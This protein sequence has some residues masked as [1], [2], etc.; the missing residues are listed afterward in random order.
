MKRTH[1]TLLAALCLTVVSSAAVFA[2]EGSNNFKLGGTAVQ[3][4][5][6]ENAV[7]EVIKIRTDV[8]PYFGTVSRRLN[9]KVTKLDNLLEFKAWF[10][11]AS[12]LGGVI[13]AQKTCFG[14]TPRMQ[15]SVDTDGNGSADANALGYYGNAFDFF[16]GCPNEVWMYE[17]FTGAGDVAITPTGAPTCSVCEPSTGRTVPNEEVE[18]DLVEFIGDPP[19][20]DPVTGLPLP[21]PTIPIGTYSWSRL[22]D[23]ITLNFP[24][25]KVCAGA[26]V[27]DVRGFADAFGEFGDIAMGTAY[28]DIITIGADTWS[29][30]AD[31]AGTL[32]RGFA[33]GCNRADHGDDDHEGDHDN[34]HDCDDDDDDYDGH[35]RGKW[36]NP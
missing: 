8:A 11:D 20:N 25:H 10:L 2:Q 32:P 30:R 14:G 12:G 24:N 18:W 9:T 16:S 6:P 3:A 5:D 27:D 31:T 22:E 35:R 19:G 34:D 1:W 23:Y 15:L 21:L 13:G 36:G 28:Y 17:D 4:Y 7:N 33:M 29:T 26:L